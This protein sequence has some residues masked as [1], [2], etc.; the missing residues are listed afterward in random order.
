MVRLDC[1]AFLV[2]AWV[3]LVVL[4]GLRRWW[5]VMLHCREILATL[6]VGLGGSWGSGASL[7][8]FACLE[9]DLG[10]RYGWF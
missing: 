1:R 3:V 4:R 7:S 6:V 8:G 5:V 9:G 2:S 10:R